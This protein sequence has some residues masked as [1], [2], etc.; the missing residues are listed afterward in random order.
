L[1]VIFIGGVEQ[2]AAETYAHN[3]EIWD[4]PE[5]GIFAAIVLVDPMDRI[6]N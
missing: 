1:R 3:T 5:E 4:V 2:G 6:Q